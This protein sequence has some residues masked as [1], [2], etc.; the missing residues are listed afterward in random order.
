[1]PFVVNI[2]EAETIKLKESAL[3]KR[4]KF[5]KLFE[6]YTSSNKFCV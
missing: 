5:A 2:P 6:L 3:A 1:M 4:V